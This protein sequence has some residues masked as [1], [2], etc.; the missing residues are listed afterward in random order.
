M[1]HTPR[2]KAAVQFALK[3]HDGQYRKESEKW[4]YAT[5]L[6]LVGMLLTEA[7]ADEDTVIAGL[8]HDTI[9]DTKTT[10]EEI[11]AAFGSRVLELVTAVTEPSQSSME[12][13]DRKD[14]YL[15]KLSEADDSA[16]L[17]SI[18]DKIDNVESKIEAYG[19]QGEALLGE[20]SQAPEK[21][22]WFH[23]AVA[24]MAQKRLPNNILTKRLLEACA[25][26]KELFGTTPSV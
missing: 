2:I 4:P 1:R 14:A 21:Y 6:I 19:R 10:E 24:E 8:L 7:E 13:Q 9:E 3:K 15:A 25:R 5:H 11:R 16:L 17:I 12:W 26:E 23:G 18:A 20:W 22:L